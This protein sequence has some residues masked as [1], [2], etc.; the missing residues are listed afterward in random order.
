MVKGRGLWCAIEPPD[1][2]AITNLSTLAV[3]GLRR[4]TTFDIPPPPNESQQA[5]VVTRICLQFCCER[6]RTTFWSL[7]NFI[8]LRLFSIRSRGTSAAPLPWLPP[9]EPETKQKATS[10]TQPCVKIPVQPRN[11][12]KHRSEETKVKIPFLWLEFAPL[13]FLVLEDSCSFPFFIR[14]S[15]ITNK[16]THCYRAET[17]SH[18]IHSFPFVLDEQHRAAAN[19]VQSTQSHMN[20]EWARIACFFDRETQSGWRNCT[21]NEPPKS[22]RCP[23]ERHRPERSEKWIRPRNV[24][25]PVRPLSAIW[26]KQELIHNAP[27]VPFTCVNL[28]SLHCL[29]GIAVTTNPG[30]MFD[31]AQLLLHPHQGQTES[32]LELRTQ[33]LAFSVSSD[34]Y[35][36]TRCQTSTSYCHPCSCFFF[37]WQAL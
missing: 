27:T 31:H 33:F 2:T 10:S 26:R 25:S 9:L 28:V 8:G 17:E 1:W 32:F 4:C 16:I 18:Q 19:N 12:Q 30:V 22:K 7:N 34:S 21:S 24:P 35:L 37:S 11:L 3:R 36:S 5:N 13:W 23:W 15:E 29:C 20:H 14:E 6:K